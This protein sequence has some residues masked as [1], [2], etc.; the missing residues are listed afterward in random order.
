M[1][2]YVYKGQKEV[3]V[4]TSF[5][6]MVARNGIQVSRIRIKSSYSLPHFFDL[7]FSCVYSYNQCTP[8]FSILSQACCWNSLSTCTLKVKRC[9]LEIDDEKG[10]LYKEKWNQLKAYFPAFCIHFCFA[11]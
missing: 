9:C 4:F 8:T 1:P 2:F 5:Y 11:L 6:H 7:Q 10:D 3:P